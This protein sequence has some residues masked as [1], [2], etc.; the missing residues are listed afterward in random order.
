M[1]N[2]LLVR[3]VA[4][5]GTFVFYCQSCLTLPV[6]YCK[7]FSCSLLSVTPVTSKN[8]ILFGKRIYALK[9]L[10]AGVGLLASCLRR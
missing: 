7:P 6:A 3:P 1:G 9:L 2:S 8:I 5:F 4:C 10:D